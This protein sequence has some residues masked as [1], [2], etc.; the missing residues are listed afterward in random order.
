MDGKPIRCNPHFVSLEIESYT[1]SGTREEFW[2]L[3]ASGPMALLGT[4]V[5]GAGRAACRVET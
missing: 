1:D 5:I 2:L 3:V 4:G